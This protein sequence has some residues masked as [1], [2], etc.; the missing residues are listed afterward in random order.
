MDAILARR[1]LANEANTAQ[2]EIDQRIRRLG[3]SSRETE[4][5]FPILKNGLYGEVNLSALRPLNVVSI[6]N[7]EPSNITE[8]YGV[9]PT[10][11]RLQ[12]DNQLLTEIKGLPRG[13]Q[14]LYLNGNYFEQIDVSNLPKLK[15]LSLNNNRLKNLTDLPESLEEL[16]VDNN[17]IGRLD[18]D[19]LPNLRIL[20]CRNNRTLR[21]ENIPASM[22]DLRVEEGNPLVILDYA[23]MPSNASTEDGKRARGTELEF[24]EA[25]HKYFALK[26]KYENGARA[27]RERVRDHAIMRGLGLKQAQKRV[28]AAKP[29]CVS[30]KRPV[31]SVFK[32][33]ED[34]LIAYCGDAREPCGLKIEIFRG[35]FESDDAFSQTTRESLLDV[36]ERIIKQKMDVLFNY[37]SEEETVAKFK[38][39]IE[40]YNLLSFLHKTDLDMREDKRFNSHKKELIKGKL[41]RIA[42]LKS[43]MNMHLDEYK[44]SESKDALHLAMDIYAREYMPEIHN[45]RM[46]RYS[47]MEM[48]VPPGGDPKNKIR[49]LNQSAASLRQLETLHGEVPRVLSFSVGL[50]GK[51]A[52]KEPDA[53]ELDD[54]DEEEEEQEGGGLIPWTREEE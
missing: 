6:V 32:I 21:I 2:N 14:K 40:E 33:K 50:T 49:V 46:L 28:V 10:V 37:S 45:L 43:A 30:C 52:Q 5:A 9:P 41:A 16:Y 3:A 54:E 1:N 38:D 11:E 34:R 4:F 29:K 39:L 25:L 15:V 31:S 27:L 47:V 26:T 44:E 18:L 23:F 20:H 7:R 22:V 19:G 53:L 12:I 8:I 42:E 48:E 51:P 13:L 24:V 17:Q 35:Q 36:K